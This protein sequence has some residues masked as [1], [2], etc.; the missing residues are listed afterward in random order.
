MTEILLIKSEM[1]AAFQLILNFSEVWVAPALGQ[2]SA[3]IKVALFKF[4]CVG[5]KKTKL[6]VFSFPL[7][8]CCDD[9]F[10]WNQKEEIQLCTCNIC[11]D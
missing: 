2:A 10:P 11:L 7:L 5:R 6:F 3:L 1:V 9:F 4:W 8:S